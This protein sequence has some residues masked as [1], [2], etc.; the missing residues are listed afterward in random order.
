MIQQNNERTMKE[1][2]EKIAKLQNLFAFINNT[3]VI[4]Y[5]S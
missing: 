4:L 5:D 1:Q 2:N 3:L